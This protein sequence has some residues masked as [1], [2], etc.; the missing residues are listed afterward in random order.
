MT[1]HPVTLPAT[2]SLA[3]A[4]AIMRTRNLKHMPVVDAQ[5]HLL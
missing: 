2:T 5:N 4:A 3:Q 1:P